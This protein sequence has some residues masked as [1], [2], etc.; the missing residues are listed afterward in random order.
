[1]RTGEEFPYLYT[2]VSKHLRWKSCLSRLF[3]HENQF[4]AFSWAQSASVG[5]SC[6]L[7]MPRN[8]EK[9]LRR[10]TPA[11]LPSPQARINR[12][13]SAQACYEDLATGW[14]R[15]PLQGPVSTVYG[16]VICPFDF[17]FQLL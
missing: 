9:E 8:N 3:I 5:S 13:V 11:S 2:S 16:Q 10:D 14:L 1:M 6:G 17:S 4:E 12:G 15:W 7:A